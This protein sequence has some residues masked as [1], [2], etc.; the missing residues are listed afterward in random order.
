MPGF[1]KEGL[2]I[3]LF[4]VV[5]GIAYNYLSGNNLPLWRST[6]VKNFF[7][8]NEEPKYSDL[9]S[10]VIKDTVFID[11]Q[12]AKV[13]HDSGWAVFVD[14]R[15]QDD[16]RYGFIKGA[17]SIPYNDVENRLTEL[18]HVPVD[19]PVVVYC[20]GAECNASIKLTSVLESMGYRYVFVFFGGWN[21]WQNSGLPVDTLYKQ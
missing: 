1:V 7:S 9:V 17:V 20:D 18:L 14:A 11:L 15:P 8:F 6:P 16:L 2:I 4:S 19:T 12:T 21:E 3:I 10:R 13:I 5:V